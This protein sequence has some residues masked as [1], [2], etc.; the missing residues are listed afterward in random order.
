[1]RAGIVND[2][3]ISDIDS[4]QPAVNGKLIVILTKTADNIVKVVFRGV[5]LAHNGDVVIS[6][7]HSRTHKVAGAGIKTDI[8]LVDMLLVNCRGYKAAIGCE[9]EA[10]KLSIKR[11]ITHTGGNKYLIINLLNSLTNRHNVGRLLI[12]TVGYAYAAGE[13][14][15]RDMY[16][17]LIFKLHGK[18][19]QNRGKCGIIVVGDGVAGKKSMNAEFLNA[20]F[21]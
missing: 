2:N 19:E 18:T 11:N 8:V 6:A 9:H 14:D 17:K 7:V 4:R 16:V 20:L 15:K 3:E 5:L 1:M 10:T 21:L 12:L 13:V